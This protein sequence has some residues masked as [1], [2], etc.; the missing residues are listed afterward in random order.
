MSG[1]EGRSQTGPGLCTSAM[2]DST[3]M[4]PALATYTS[5]SGS[6]ECKRVYALWYSIMFLAL[7]RHLLSDP[8][9]YTSCNTTFFGRQYVTKSNGNKG[10]DYDWDDVAVCA[11]P[12]QRELR[13]LRKPIPH[14]GHSDEGPSKHISERGTGRTCFKRNMEELRTCL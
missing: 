10:H 8:A 13:P 6:P 12:R 11:S 1:V 9:A 4:T 2:L 3:L 5:P 7:P 14:S